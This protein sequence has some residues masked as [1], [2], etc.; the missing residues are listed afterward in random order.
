MKLF[1]I[2][3]MNFKAKT[4]QFDCRLNVE[5]E[6]HVELIRKYLQNWYAEGG[7]RYVH[8]SGVEIGDNKNY[9]SYGKEHVHIGLVLQNP[10]TKRSIIKKLIWPRYLSLGWY[11]EFRNKTLPVEGWITY[12]RKAR[13]KVNP[14]DQLLLQLGTVPMNSRKMSES[15]EPQRKKS[16][17]EEYARKKYLIQTNQL[18]ILDQ[19][20]PGF[21]YTSLGR[22]MKI[23]CMK[24]IVHK[25]LEGELNNYIIY[26]PTGTGKSSSI[27]LLYPRCYKKQKG[28]KYWDGYDIHNPD[29]EVVWIDE[30]SKETLECMAGNIRGGFEH[31]KELGDRYPVSVDAKYIGSF[32]IRPKSIII[33]MNEHPSTLLP[34]R[35]IVV[36]KEALHR[37]FHILHVQDWLK[38][39]K[40][41]NTSSGAEYLSH[42]YF[43]QEEDIPSS[44]ETIEI[45]Y[46]DRN[47]NTSNVTQ[48]KRRKYST[49]DQGTQTET[50]YFVPEL[51]FSDGELEQLFRHYE[52]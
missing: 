22:N 36:N 51:L 8:M 6:H 5:N 17:V 19:E 14:E 48:R 28:H 41:R 2:I 29:H 47:I 7:L 30:M 15:E 52:A 33:T 50:A 39:K 34:D 45:E 16:K 9:S 25:P 23:D 42:Y 26:G 18:H 3:R 40:L 21:Q 27:A 38:L 11:I 13:T 20:Y 10:T 4:D 32:T 46:E 37:K 31:L 1:L 43:H 35:A 49:R 24:Q 44:Q 12:A